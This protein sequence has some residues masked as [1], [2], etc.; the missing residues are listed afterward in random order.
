M[1]ESSFEEKEEFEYQNGGVGSEKKDGGVGKISLGAIREP[2]FDY[3][4]MGILGLSNLMFN[5]SQTKQSS[6]IS[7]NFTRKE[8]ISTHV[9]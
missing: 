7:Q 1:R 5:S 9:M 4:A 6:F 3:D 2:A 8:S